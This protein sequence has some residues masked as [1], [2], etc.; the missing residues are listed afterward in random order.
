M[1]DGGLGVLAGAHPVIE[2][3][4]KTSLQMPRRR[5]MRRHKCCDGNDGGQ[6]DGTFHSLIVTTAHFE[7]GDGRKA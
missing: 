7:I 2:R 4:L 3:S 1:L 6:H 5:N